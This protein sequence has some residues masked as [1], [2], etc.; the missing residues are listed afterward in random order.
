MTTKNIEVDPDWRFRKLVKRI[1]EIRKSY[2]AALNS[3]NYPYEINK[4]LEIRISCLSHVLDKSTDIGMDM[5]ILIKG[6][7]FSDEDE[8]YDPWI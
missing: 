7:D 1:Q 3:E 6:K 5:P 4:D 8:R 2:R